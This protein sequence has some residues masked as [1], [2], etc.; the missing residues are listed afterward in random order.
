MNFKLLNERRNAAKARAGSNNIMWKP[1]VGEYQVRIVPYQHNKDWPFSELWFH[2]NITDKP[3]LS[4]ITFGRRDP[5]SEFG[6]KLKATGKPD[7]KVLG[8]ML[9][10]S[11]RI[12]VPIIVRG[13][14][15]EGV[16][17]WGMSD[18]IYQQLMDV[19]SDPDYGDITDP[20]SGHDIK[21]VIIPNKGT[22]KYTN[23]KTQIESVR[24]RPKSSPLS[25][26]AEVLELIKV[27]PDLLEMFPEPSSDD[28]KELLKAFTENGGPVKSEPSKG[29]KKPTT[30]PPPRDEDDDEDPGDGDDDDEYA[31][32]RV[33]DEDD[34]E[35]DSPVTKPNTAD[36]KAAFAV[37]FKK[38]A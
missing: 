15:K 2:Y 7:N 26:D 35:D 10:P 17:F 14:E 18:K 32:E 21:V 20:M 33:V 16:K 31:N 25:A 13:A 12:Y 36:A 19:I 11:L 23:A 28:L 37:Y 29:V 24:V 27:M 4:P 22:G 38:K 5:I 34:D 30:A 9:T 8:K 1:E 6:E 3:V